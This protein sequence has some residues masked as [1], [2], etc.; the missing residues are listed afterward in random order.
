MKLD[1]L[2]KAGL[3]EDKAKAILEMHEKE[4]AGLV[5]KKDE[6][7]NETKKTKELLKQFEGLDAEQAKEAMKKLKDLDE[8]KLLDKGEYEKLLNAKKS[9]YEVML[10][11]LKEKSEK[12]EA[13]IKNVLA[14]QQLTD[15]LVKSG[16]T[17]PVYL[18]VLQD[19]FMKNVS[20]VADADGYSVLC[21]DK[22]IQQTIQEFAKTDEAKHFISA[23]PNTGGGAN[24]SKKTTGTGT[25]TVKEI[26]KKGSENGLTQKDKRML[27]SEKLKGNISIDT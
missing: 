6:L 25:D 1:D 2:I 21:G 22:T 14:K 26:Y 23:T 13:Y 19:K 16:V 24:G 5:S 9:E 15:E 27:I 12:K 18:E 3:E 20:A 4:T 17:N 10:S 11:E 8:K 7:L